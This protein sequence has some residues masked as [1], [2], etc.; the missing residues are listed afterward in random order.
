MPITIGIALRYKDDLLDD[1]ATTVEEH[2]KIIQETGNVWL[3]KF[4]V[5]IISATLKALSEPGVEATLILIRS[6]LAKNDDRPKM[7][8]A[9]FSGARNARPQSKLI[10]SYYRKQRDIDTWFCLTSEIRPLT[11]AEA[12]AWVI[13]STGEGLL[14]SVRRCPRQFFLIS[15]KAGLK[16]CQKFLAGF[17][18]KMRATSGPTLPQRRH[19]DHIVYA[20][21]YHSTLEE[22]DIVESAW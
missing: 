12:K 7:F 17:M 13:I 15:R 5:P 9:P 19:R 1:G 10:P 18:A 11:N 21:D 6:K 4:G 14:V 22:T 3:G 8:S 16:R 2:N 20:E